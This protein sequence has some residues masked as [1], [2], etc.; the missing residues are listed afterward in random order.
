MFWRKPQSLDSTNQA[1]KDTGLLINYRSESGDSIRVKLTPKTIAILVMILTSLLGGAS[2]S[3]FSQ[4]STS[5]DPQSEKLTLQGQ[6]AIPTSPKT[7][8]EA[9]SSK[10][11]PAAGDNSPN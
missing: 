4:K 9:S 2:L 8:Q 11:L 10:V 6:P 7:K 3:A 1:D 5:T